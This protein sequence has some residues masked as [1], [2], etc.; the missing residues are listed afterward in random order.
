MTVAAYVPR[1][2]AIQHTGNNA[3]EIT[4]WVQ[5]LAAQYGPLLGWTL[6]SIEL[7][8]DTD[9]LTITISPFASPFILQ[10]TQYLVFNAG[11]FVVQPVDGFEVAFAPLVETPVVSAVGILDVPALTPLVNPA[12][13]LNIP[14]S[15]QFAN[16]DYTVEAKLIGAKSLLGIV[17]L[18]LNGPL[19]TKLTAGSVRV[20]VQA[21]LAYTAGAQVLVV[22]HGIAA[23]AV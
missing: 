17:P 8:E 21:S 18:V 22:A 9:I 16:L 4:T 20:R 7:D 14:L 23:P 10:P 19:V 13:N 12:E 11:T 15:R 5:Q 3:A 2:D 1:V 6:E